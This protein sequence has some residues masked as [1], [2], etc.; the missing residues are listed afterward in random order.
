M[1]FLNLKT[2]KPLSLDEKVAIKS[3]FGR[4]I[5]TLP[6][7]SEEWLMVGFDDRE[8]SLWFKGS[9]APCAILEAKVYGSLTDED[10]ERFTEAVTKVLTKAL[11]IPGDRIY[12]KYDY[13][14]HWGYDGSN[15]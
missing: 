14:A 10:A 2:N 12:V 4:L 1:P 7:K 9:D 15:F 8:E 11:S 5:D 13:V 6:G 3:A